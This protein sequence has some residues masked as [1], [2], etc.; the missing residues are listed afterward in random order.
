MTIEGTHR[1]PYNVGGFLLLIEGARF[2]FTSINDL[3][4][5]GAGSWIGTAYGDRSIKLGLVPPRELDLGETDPWA[6]KLAQPRPVNFGLL[7][8]DGTVVQLFK[9]FEPDATTDTMGSRLGPLDDPAPAVVP[10]PNQTPIDLWGRHV[11]TEAIGPA[12]ERR[13]FW[14]APDDVPPGLDHFAGAGWPPALITDEP[15]VWAGRRC[16]LYRI[17]QDPDTG[18][19]PDL[20]EQYE[21]GGLW[22]YGTVKDRGMWRDSKDGRV[23]Q[24]A[25]MGASSWLRKSLNMSRPSRW[26]SARSQIALE[27]DEVLVAAWIGNHPL[28]QIGD[29]VSIIV[30]TYPAQTL[31]SG[32]TLAGLTTRE[33]IWTK[34]GNIVQTMINNVDTGGILAATNATWTGPNPPAPSG[35]WGSNPERQVTISAD[36]SSIRIRCENPTAP[37]P[38]EGYWLG[39]A[40]SAKVWQSAGWDIGNGSQYN[41]VCPVG[42]SRWGEVDG[43]QIMPNAH[44]VLEFQ[45]RDN[46]T[47]APQKWANGGNWQTYTPPYQQGTVTLDPDAGDEL[48]LGVGVV[49]NEGQ[50]AQPWTSGA[51]IDGDDVTASGWWIFR[52]ERLTAAAFLAGKDPEPYIQIALCEWVATSDGDGVEIDSQGYARIR[53]IRWEH[54]RRFGLDFDRLEEPWVSVEGGLLCAPLAVLGGTTSTQDWRHRVIPRIL[55]SSGTATWLDTGDAVEVVPGANQ[56]AGLPDPWPGDMEAADLGLGMP[57][58]FVDVESWR[59]ACA[60][61]PG[62]LA[63]ALNRVKY[64]VLGPMQAETI[65]VDAMSG[66]GLAWSWQRRA[67]EKVPSFGCYDPVAPVTLEQV[68]ETLSREDMA[69]LKIG[70]DEQWR[71]SVELRRRGPFDTFAYAVG[72][73]PMEPGSKD[74]EVTHEAQDWGRRYRQGNMV[75]PVRDGGLRDPSPWLGTVYDDIYN[76]ESEARDRFP[77]GFALRYARQVRVYRGSYNARFAGRLGLGTIVRVID[78]TAESPD[79]TR[80]ID[81]MGRITKAVIVTRGAGALVTRVAVELE[82]EGVDQVKV[83]GPAAQADVGSWDGVDTLAVSTDWGDVGDGHDDLTGFTQ[84]PW[85]TRA[86]GPL[87]VVIYQSEDGIDFPASLEVR[88]DVASVGASTITLAA[89]AGTIYRDMI[90]WVVAAPYDE[91]TAEWPLGLYIPITEPTGLWNGVDSGWRL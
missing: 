40:L 55:L 75:W 26:V 20:L 74:Y 57:A 54:P 11:G 37:N 84:P 21:G 77:A 85:D 91:Q 38:D 88:A 53:T 2:G 39:I 48:T 15:T 81:H 50:L 27:G 70:D 32:N 64:P 23:L 44:W 24:L 56:P 30:G 34:I 65:L 62:G 12:G 51:T 72:R 60:T 4:G 31:I 18:E 82:P 16:A 25:C 14:I 76:W 80:G 3:V 68:Q 79:G 63:G 10:G 29:G 19:W 87:R 13:H 43:D 78:P 83:W 33:E 71:G 52:G 49:R 1:E 5:E 9:N 17:V 7:D 6:G 86:A 22:W 8:F 69:E 89:I 36:G 35:P 67:G 58:V 45:T 59:T 61:L 90:K 66:A 46:H 41:G 47:D 73:S 28:R 42:G